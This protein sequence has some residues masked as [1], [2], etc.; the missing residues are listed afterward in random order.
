M[1]AGCRLLARTF[2]DVRNSDAIGGEP[3]MS[4]N[5]DFGRE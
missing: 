2:S 4:L 3:D 5:A 1:Q